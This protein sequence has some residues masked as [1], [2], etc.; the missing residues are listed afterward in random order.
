M[1]RGVAV[2]QRSLTALAKVQIL[3]GQPLLH[4]LIIFF[5]RYLIYMWLFNPYGLRYYS[6]SCNVPRFNANPGFTI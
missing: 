6:V 5:N 3:A 1:S 2:A 4:Y